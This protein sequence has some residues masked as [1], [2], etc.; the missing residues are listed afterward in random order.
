MTWGI[1]IAEF[2]VEMEL[3]PQK[4]SDGKQYFDSQL[5][6]Y[7]PKEVWYEFRVKGTQH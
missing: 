2:L 3:F 1:K 6:D 7:I 5:V 4:K